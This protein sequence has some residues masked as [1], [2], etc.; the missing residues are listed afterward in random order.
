[1]QYEYEITRENIESVYL[2]ADDTTP[3][4]FGIADTHACLHD[5]LTNLTTAIH[6]TCIYISIPIC[7]SKHAYH[8]SE[9]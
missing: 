8:V 2:L 4:H 6:E 7:F 5:N 1:M 9:E 3:K